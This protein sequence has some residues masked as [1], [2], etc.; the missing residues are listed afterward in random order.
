MLSFFSTRIGQ[1]RDAPVATQE[2]LGVNYRKL[3]VMYSILFGVP[4]FLGIP[5]MDVR[6]CKMICTCINLQDVLF[7]LDTKKKCD[8]AKGTITCSSCSVSF[9]KVDGKIFKVDSGSNFCITKLEM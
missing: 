4:T 9:S 8:T 5:Q 7:H 1:I 3:L 6:Y 2:P